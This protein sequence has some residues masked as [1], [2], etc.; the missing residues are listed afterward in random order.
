MSNATNIVLKRD[1]ATDLT[2]VPVSSYSSGEGKLTASFRELSTTKPL[3]A[4]VRLTVEVESMKSGVMKVTRKL[5]VPVMEIIPAGAVNAD[6]RTAAPAVSHVETDIRTRYHHPRST[7]TERADSLKM[8]THVDVGASSGAGGG[9][10][11]T[12]TTAFA[13]R[14]VTASFQIPYG[15]INYVWPSA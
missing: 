6:G 8:A 14:D 13:W 4:C 15:D 11:V 1:D 5:E 7:A 3:A 10:G 9:L 2:L 12:S